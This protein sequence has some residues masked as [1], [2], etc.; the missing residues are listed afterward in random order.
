MI[1]Y[2]YAY[3][4]KTF[5][6]EVKKKFDK[7][8]HFQISFLLPFGVLAFSLHTHNQNTIHII[9]SDHVVDN[10]HNHVFAFTAFFF[11]VLSFSFLAPHFEETHQF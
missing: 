1:F 9:R 4:A 5:Q 11:V 10:C 3:K 2:L 7:V 6:I 8:A